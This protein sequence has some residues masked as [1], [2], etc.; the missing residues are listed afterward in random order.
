MGYAQKHTHTQN[1]PEIEQRECWRL[2]L[3]EAAMAT[4]TASVH[5]VYPSDDDDAPIRTH[6]LPISHI[7][8]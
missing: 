6:T 1:A 2:L 5:S 8:M 7:S 3:C 4:H